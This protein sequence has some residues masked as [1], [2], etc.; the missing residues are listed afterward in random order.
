MAAAAVAHLVLWLGWLRST[1]TFSLN[2]DVVSVTP[3]KDGPCKGLPN[4]VG[5]MELHLL[6]ETK[7]NRTRVGDF[8]SLCIGARPGHLV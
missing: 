3:P 8:L 6:P 7:S 5:V 1:E 4:G 2:W